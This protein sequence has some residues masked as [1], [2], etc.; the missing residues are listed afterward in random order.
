MFSYAGRTNN[1]TQ[2][3][4]PTRVGGFGGVEGLEAYLN[5]ENITHVIDATHPF[6]AQM[7]MNAVAACAN[8][9]V[10]LC[11]FE[12][13]AWTPDAAD[14][15]QFVPDMAGAVAALPD[16]PTRV[17]LAIGRQHI[18]DFAVKPQ[19]DYLLRLVDPP[20]GALPLPNAEAV[21]ARGPFT[22]ADDTGLMENHG[23][24]LIVAKNGGG[25]GARAKLDAA[26][27]LGVPVIIID[28]PAIAPRTILRSVDEVMGWL[29]HS[30][31]RG[32]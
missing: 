8:T 12:R 29:P 2:Q 31:R 9:G 5:A 32:V 18:A 27:A 15:W 10:S 1:P 14:D 21:V 24:Q 20:E 28:R 26:R 17:F 11:A 13:E 30:A 3:P 23:T 25:L 19:H 22:V 4:L 6:A 16:D 7:S